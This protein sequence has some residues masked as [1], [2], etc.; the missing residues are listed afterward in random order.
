MKYDNKLKMYSIT[1][2]GFIFYGSTPDK[3]NETFK[4]CLKLWNI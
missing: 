2:K 4:H 1:Y 3:C